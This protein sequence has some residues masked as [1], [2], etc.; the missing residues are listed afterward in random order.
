LGHRANYVVIESGKQE[1][2]FAN[3]GALNL[4]HDIFFGPQITGAFMRAH[5]PD[6]SLLNGVFCEGAALLDLDEHHL[7]F[8]SWYV[9]SEPV[10]A[11]HYVALAQANYPGWSI[12]H[13]REG[14]IGICRYMGR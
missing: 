7:L 3:W 14:I 5:V 2:Y 12:E 6:D 9:L 11:Q 10:V 8:F 4:A 13:A 1:V